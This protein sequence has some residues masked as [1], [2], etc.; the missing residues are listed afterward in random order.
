MGDE[1]SGAMGESAGGLTGRGEDLGFTLSEVGLEER[2]VVV[3]CDMKPQQQLENFYQ[4][5]TGK[6]SLVGRTTEVLF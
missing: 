1:V 5:W 6:S 3:R 4:G 2:T